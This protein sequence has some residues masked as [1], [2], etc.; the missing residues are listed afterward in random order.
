MPK[1]CGI[2]GILKIEF[3]S[4]SGTERIKQNRKKVKYH[5]KPRKLVRKL[6]FK[7][8]QQKP[9][10]FFWFFTENL[11]LL[12]SVTH[13]A[14]YNTNLPSNSKFSKT[15]RADIVFAER[16]LKSI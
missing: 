1:V 5:S 9:C 6:L 8:F 10:I 4:F 12:H 16:I 13:C 14:G 3:F 2:I 7:Q 15:M 11:T